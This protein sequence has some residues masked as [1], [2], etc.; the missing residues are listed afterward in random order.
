MI[1][2][3]ICRAAVTGVRAGDLEDSHDGPVNGT[4]P[5]VI[6]FSV[7]CGHRVR[8]VLRKP[9]TLDISKKPFGNPAV[10]PAGLITGGIVHSK[11]GFVIHEHDDA[12]VGCV[13]L[14]HCNRGS[15]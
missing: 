15:W 6:G 2:V 9:A 14:L 13:F 7:P 12:G 5:A 1:H 3:P 8:P 11:P 10:K 4:D